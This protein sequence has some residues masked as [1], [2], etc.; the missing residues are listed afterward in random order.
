MGAGLTL[1]TL[2]A[3]RLRLEPVADEHLD[4]LVDLNADPEVMRYILG[5]A[6]TPEETHEEWAERR[7][8]R[9]DTARGL[10]YWLGFVDG[11][12]VGW[13]S[14]SSFAADPAVSGVGYRLRRSAWGLGY[15]TEGARVV[16]RQAFADPGIDRV[17][18]STMAVNAGS[19]AVLAKLGLRHTD[20]WVREWEEPIPGWEQGEVLYELTREEHAARC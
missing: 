17:L 16:I 14:A 20:T 13:W 9:T 5:R 11:E 6:A 19:R 2:H 3:E 8:P 12:F 10:G 18:A 15:A 1:P 7:G 4:L